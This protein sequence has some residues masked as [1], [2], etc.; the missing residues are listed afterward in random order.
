MIKNTVTKRNLERKVISFSSPSQLYFI[1]VGNSNR[2][3]K[4]AC[5]IISTVKSREK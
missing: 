4:F 2:N 5:P 1:T 3:F